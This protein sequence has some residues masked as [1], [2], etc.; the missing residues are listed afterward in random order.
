MR[1]QLQLTEAKN[2]FQQEALV[3]CLNRIMEVRI[4]DLNLK[5]RMLFVEFTGPKV[6]QKIQKEIE[7]LG[8]AIGEKKILPD[9]FAIAT[10]KADSLNTSK[11]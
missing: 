3:R 2:A 8:L 6:F 10:N 5:K 4:L 7:R 9:P 11:V 1:A